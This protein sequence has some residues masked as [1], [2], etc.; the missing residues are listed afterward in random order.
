MI[1]V[2]SVVVVV[3]MFATHSLVLFADLTKTARMHRLI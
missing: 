1:S 2:I 3:S